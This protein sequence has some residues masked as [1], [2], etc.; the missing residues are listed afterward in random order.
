VNLL[1]RRVS[2]NLPLRPYHSSRRT[3]TAANPYRES[4]SRALG[5]N[6]GLDAVSRTGIGK[7]STAQAL[8]RPRCAALLN[9]HDLNLDAA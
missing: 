8:A 4:G 5:A 3:T 6:S 1:P 9:R 7:S 2:A